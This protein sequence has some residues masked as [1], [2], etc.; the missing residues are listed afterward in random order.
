MA[1]SSRE[2]TKMSEVSAW[3]QNSEIY[4]ANSL[5]LTAPC[6][7]K[8]SQDNVF[9][10]PFCLY[11]GYENT[12]RNNEDRLELDEKFGSRSCMEFW[13]PLAFSSVS[14]PFVGLLSY[15]EKGESTRTQRR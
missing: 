15:F 1:L 8:I 4:N 12:H 3:Q 14:L 2:L 7:F 6:A 13:I 9:M 11:F 5:N 10:I